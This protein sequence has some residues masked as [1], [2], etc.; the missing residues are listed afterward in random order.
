VY[1]DRILFWNNGQLPE[2]W[3]VERLMSKHPSQAYNPDIAN[4][5]S[6]TGMIEAWERGIEKVMQVCRNAGLALPSLTYE[7]LG[8]WVEFSYPPMSQSSGEATQEWLLAL[9]RQNPP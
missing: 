6:R 9:L 2:D 7:K 8:L 1:D 4:A 5:F 3:T